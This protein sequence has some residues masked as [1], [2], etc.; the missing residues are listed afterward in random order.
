VVLSQTMVRIICGRL[1]TRLRL[2]IGEAGQTLNDRI[3][4]PLFHIG[5]GVADAAD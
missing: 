1:V 2:D 4:D 3:V 5:S